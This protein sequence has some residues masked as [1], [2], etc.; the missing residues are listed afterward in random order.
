MLPVTASA[1]AEANPTLD[2]S[3]LDK[4]NGYIYIYASKFSTYAVG[5]TASHTI[6]FDANGGTVTPTE[7]P[8]GSNGKLSTLPTPTWDGYTFKG[9]YTSADGGTA[10]TTDTAF[11]GSTTIYAHWEKKSSQGGGGGGGGGWYP[12]VSYYSVK[13]NKSEHG[14]VTASPT[15]SSSGSTVTLNAKPDEGYKL[16]K[17][18]VTDSQDKA[19][20]LTEKNG[21]YS[22][23]MPSRDVTVKAEFVPADSPSPEP[24]G[25]P[26]P[27]TSPSPS[28]DSWNNP[29]PDVSNTDWY[30]KAVE[31]VCTNGLMAGYENGKFGPNDTLSRAQLAQIIYNKEGRPKADSGRFSDVTTGWYANAV[32]WAAA[33]GIVAGVGDGKFAP[34]QPISRQDL[35][36]M[37][38]RYAGSPEPRKNELDF[39]DAGK[40]SEYAWKA[41]CWANENGIVNGKGNRV[42]DP[43]GKAT[44]AEAAQMLKNYIEDQKDKS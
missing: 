24:T 10:V 42:L 38:W 15:S 1:A 25:S 27:T 8:T 39:S 23:K 13:V 30:I 4:E 31:Y 5:Y 36:V 3:K 35:A 14:T 16:D 22:F 32:N 6:T 7:A 9:W 37:L 12:S 26:T 33:E 43:K 19:V 21:K 44:R 20:E 18:T 28:P 2:V 41:L 17:I 29:F 34:D 40:V 11:T